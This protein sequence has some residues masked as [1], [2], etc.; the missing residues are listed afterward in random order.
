MSIVSI[1]AAILEEELR[2][3]GIR[4]LTQ[5]DLETIVHSMIERTAELETH[6]QQRHLGLR[7]DDQN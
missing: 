6:I 7:L 3:H 4:G 1:M 2:E 5:R